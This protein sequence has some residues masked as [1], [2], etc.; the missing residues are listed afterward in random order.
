M[1]EQSKNFW[2]ARSFL[3]E[4]VTGLSVLFFNDTCDSISFVS[5]WFDFPAMEER[6]HERESRRSL[7]SVVGKS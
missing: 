3:I 4:Y 7:D 2:S 5:C 6:L 1:S